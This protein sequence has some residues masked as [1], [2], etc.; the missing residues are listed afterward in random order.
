M[1]KPMLAYSKTPDLDSINYP[2][3][4]SPKLDGVR[5]LIIDGVAVSRS[6]KPIPN[7]YVQ[8]LIGRE[9][10]NGL[11]GELTLRGAKGLDFNLNQS[12]FMSRTGKP[13]F[14]FNVF[15]SFNNH[16]DEFV[17]R[18]DDASHIVDKC[19]SLNVI[20]VPHKRFSGPAT[21]RDFWGKCVDAGYEGAIVRDM[22]GPYK[23]GRSTLKQGWMLKLKDWF[24]EEFEII[25]IEELQH[26][27]NE[28]TI[29]NLG[30]Q[31]RSSHKAGQVG[32]DTLGAMWLKTAKGTGFK[33]G[34]GFD[35][36]QRKALWRIGNDLIGKFASIKHN[37][38]SK[39]G[40]PR[41]PVFKGL[42][43]AIDR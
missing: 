16:K 42:R 36:E 22:H 34:T 8:Q 21:L 9:E 38:E 13:A 40:V 26:N 3:F 39:Y 19:C 1:F 6:L 29:D 7:L 33:V 37:G 32:G 41:F 2:V 24:D 25:A 20:S 35:A 10:L 23:H 4:A 5:C 15:D 11:D 27:E 30:N 18:L 14:V 17:K 12:A 43:D 31:V 28:A